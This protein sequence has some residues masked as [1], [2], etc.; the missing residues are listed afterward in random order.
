MKRNKLASDTSLAGLLSFTLLAGGC[1]TAVAADKEPAPEKKPESP[2][3]H[4]VARGPLKTKLQLDATF[5]S[6]EMKPLAIVPKAW[7]D[8][9]VLE[10]VPH[11]A[12][13]KEG[14]VVLRLDTEKLRDTVEDLERDRPGAAVALT[15]AEAELANLKETTPL[16]LEAARRSKRIAEEDYDYFQKTGRA[17]REKSARYNLK[18]AE[19]RLE[20][21]Q[22]ELK[23]LKKMYEADDLTEET[24]E[25]ILKRQKNAVEW[26]EYSLETARLSSDQSLKTSIPREH[27]ALKAARRD[28]E[29][30]LALVE[31][32]APKA[33]TKKQHEVEKL[34][35]DRKKADKRLA[36]LKKDLEQLTVRAPMDGVVYYGACETGKWASG[37]AVAKKLVPGG[38]LAPGEVFMTVVNPDSLALKAVVPEAEL[39]RARPGLEGTA[40]PV[41]APDKKLPVK[42]EE[43]SYVPLLTGGF[44]ARFSV[45]KPK[46]LRLMPG[47]ACKLA[48]ELRKPDV[49]TVPKEAV[50]GEGSQ[51]HVY[52][53]K[54]EGKH[55]KQMVKTGDS[56]GKLIE[57][58]EGLSEGDQILLKKP[59]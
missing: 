35:R 45:D 3:T 49:L 50:F 55:E 51:T 10:S 38:K 36:D 5:E 9:T 12:A 4:K 33:L 48:F 40:S 58:L 39:A 46:D 19:E 17:Q 44:E 29:L 27:E 6:T 23:Q 59:E 30:A 47:M 37:A 52:L 31:Q 22:E 21:A 43:V 24:E 34:K 41:S 28:Q 13:V 20:N 8:L 42:L 53:V 25:I 7:T 1:L 11:G 54:P 26:A 32:S 16:K 56:D 57:V 2:P 14:D 18:S 15:L